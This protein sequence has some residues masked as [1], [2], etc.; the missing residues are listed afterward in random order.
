[1]V[2]PVVCSPVRNAVVMVWALTS[3]AENKA[4]IGSR[5]MGQSFFMRAL[6]GSVVMEDG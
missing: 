1:L 2:I 4:T 3:E 6:L 5:R